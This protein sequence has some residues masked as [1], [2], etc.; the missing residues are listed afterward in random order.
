MSMTAEPQQSEFVRFWNEVLVPKFVRYKHVLVDGLGQHSEAVFPRIEV[1]P[2]ERVLD[3]GCG[4]G[5][6][7]CLLAERVGPRGEVVGIDCCEA[8]L[9]HGRAEAAARG[10]GNVG[11]VAADVEVHPFAPEHD[12]VFSRFGTMFFASPVAA[13]RNMR[14]A[15]KPGGRMVNIVWRC[16]ADNPWLSAAREVVLRHL[17]P[18]GADAATCG[19]GPFSMSDEEMVTGQ[20]R[21]AGFDEIGFERVDAK[22]MMGRDAA[23]AIGFQI[24]LGPAG[25]VYREAGELARERHDAIVADLEAMLAPWTTPEGVFMESSSWVITARNPA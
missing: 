9:E 21:A 20:L 13:L 3:V 17:P 7:A 14:R 10:L 24:A 25:E 19:P 15:L 4:F 23:D 6:T 16:R 1:N 11:F 5:D 2:G 8:F 12:L 18:P 22:V